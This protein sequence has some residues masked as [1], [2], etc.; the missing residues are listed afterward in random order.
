MFVVHEP[1]SSLLYIKHCIHQANIAPSPFLF[2]LDPLHTRPLTPQY[3]EQYLILINT[4]K[5]KAKAKAAPKKPAA[6]DAAPKAKKLTQTTTKPKAKA[7]A[8]KKR[9]KVD[10][11]DEDDEPS[12]ERA[13][14]HDDT[15]LSMTPPSGKKEKAPAKK[16]AKG[17]EPL[18]L[19][20]N[21]A[22]MDDKP[23]IPK[24]ASE[25]YQMVSLADKHTGAG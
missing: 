4:Q 23:I 1:C 15:L 8:P 6:K 12:I 17:K 21:D 2:N 20:E 14:L 19:L 13:S 16:K 10:S 24:N 11:E 9:K 3:F 5:P 22:T 7:T 18:A 25:K